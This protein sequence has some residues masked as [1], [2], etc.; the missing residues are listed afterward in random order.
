[1]NFYN[2]KCKKSLCL[3]D[4]V[5]H[6]KMGIELTKVEKEIVFL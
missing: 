4:K 2:N 1:M 5:F 3:I 6:K